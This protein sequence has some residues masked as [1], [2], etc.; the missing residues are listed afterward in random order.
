MEAPGELETASCYEDTSIFGTHSTCFVFYHSD[1]FTYEVYETEQ[2]WILDRVW[3]DYR[4]YERNQY[5]TD[6]TA[7]WGAESAYRN[8]IGTYY[9]RYSDGILVLGLGSE[10]Q[11]TEAQAA[12][13]REKLGLG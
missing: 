1:G 10:T 6:C 7:L 5:V 3:D 2:D 4:T 11:L 8:N 12:A 9:V 13:V